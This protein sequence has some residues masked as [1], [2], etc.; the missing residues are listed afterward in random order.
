MFILLNPTA[1]GNRALLRWSEFVRG[2]NSILMNANIFT[3]NGEQSD[4]SIVKTALQ[5][6]ETDFVAAGGDGTINFLLNQLFKFATKEE[7]NQIKLGAVGI[8][9]SND[10]HKPFFSNNSNKYPF[11]LNFNKVQQRD[12]CYL[13]YK[14]KDNW[15]KK[16]FLINVSIGL[17]ADGNKLFN[18]PSKL[19]KGL[20]SI[21]TN[22]AIYYTAIREILS[23]SN[24][25]VNITVDGNKQIQ[26]NLSNIGIVKNPN[27]S[28]NLRYNGEAD[29][30]NGLFKV[31]LCE[32][33][34]KLDYLKLLLALMSNNFDSLKNTRSFN[35]RKISIQSKHNFT[36]E[37]D[38]E[39]VDTNFVSF[40]ILQNKLKVCT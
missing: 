40:G 26:T 7:I 19:L 29:Y 30:V 15:K 28:G 21:N 38:G 23:F 27:F 37:F 14:Q 4:T 25:L 20:K 1:G 13:S 2:A 3:Y 33:M 31:Y 35:C 6:G 39:T 5:N 18:N 16:Y 36:V 32:E 12:V 22:S 8:G 11:N 34:S 9:S 24:K 10:F 17:T